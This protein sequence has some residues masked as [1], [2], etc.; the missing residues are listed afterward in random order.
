MEV[1]VAERLLRFVNDPLF[2]EGNE[3]VAR[4]KDR[5]R[6]CRGQMAAVMALRL[7]SGKTL[8]LE[9]DMPCGLE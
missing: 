6:P 3:I 2:Q 9:G 8:I 5:L 1:F 7:D 4:F